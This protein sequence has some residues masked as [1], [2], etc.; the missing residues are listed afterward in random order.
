MLGIRDHPSLEL[1]TVCAGT[2][3][4][5][6]FGHAARVVEQ[7]G[8]KVDSKIY[9]E[10]EGSVPAT[11]AKSIG[12]GIIELTSEFQRLQ[13][14]TVLVIG[15]RYEA[16]AAAIAAAYL[17]IPLAHIQGGEVSGSIDECARHAITKF[18]QLHFPSTMRSADY[19]IRMGEDPKT[20]FNYGCPSGDY[21]RQLDTWL[22]SDL[23][24]RF[25]VGPG[26]DI[27]RPFLLVIYHPNTTRFGTERANVEQLL[28][29]LAELRH[30]TL[31]IW[32]NID[33]GSD[34]ISKV[35]R[36]YR[37]HHA[38]DW[39]HLLKNLDPKTFQKCLK[40]TSCAVGN[41]SSFVR[42]STFYG[43]P[44]VLVGDR[45]VG[46][47]HGTNLVQ[48]PPTKQAV[49][50]AVRRQI[51]HGRYYPSQMYGNGKAVKK[52]VAKLA[53]YAPVAQ[54]HLHYIQ[55]RPVEKKSARPDSSQ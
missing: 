5:E 35:L 21:I 29:A 38:D 52:I 15:D 9:L 16:L 8:F 11:M 19:I 24:A 31:W 28:Q 12:L 55:D 37:E 3:L 26:F 18:A 27:N 22:P 50:G 47:E 30:P 23:L 33:A 40:I 4:L 49:L 7:D 14:H 32:P 13:P 6:R 51:A 54:K 42:D 53:S 45:Q 48:T 43:T 46:R 41:S 20:V 39:L 10:M 25:G 36:I 34:D 1:Q 44:V 17:N 2:M